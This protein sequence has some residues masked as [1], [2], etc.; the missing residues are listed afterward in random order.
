MQTHTHTHTRRV[1]VCSWRITTKC[2]S[3]ERANER[4]SGSIENNTNMNN[5]RG[6][7][8]NLFCNWIS[9]PRSVQNNGPCCCAAVQKKKREKSWNN[10]MLLL[11]L[12]HSTRNWKS[13]WEPSIE[14]SRRTYVIIEIRRKGYWKNAAARWFSNTA[15]T[16][17]FRCCFTVVRSLGILYAVRTF[18]RCTCA[19]FI[20]VNVIERKNKL[21]NW[22]GK[23]RDVR[24]Q[25]VE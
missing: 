11:M 19:T 10:E 9:S 7:R 16:L 6:A 20:C 21:L 2:L 24:N 5:K 3:S 13:R 4:A 25:L 14:T 12:L 8:G 17:T 23:V 22:N 15:H 18:Q 1:K